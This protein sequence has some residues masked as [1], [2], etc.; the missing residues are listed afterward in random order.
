M[1]EILA[2]SGAFKRVEL[3]VST[4]RAEDAYHSDVC[5]LPGEFRSR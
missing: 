5:S 4:Q 3:L 1:A 2:V